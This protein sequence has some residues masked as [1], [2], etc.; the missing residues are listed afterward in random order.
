MLGWLSNRRS[1]EASKSLR[2]MPSPLVQRPPVDPFA[3]GARAE[4]EV[5]AHFRRNL[6]STTL[7]LFNIQFDNNWGD[8]DLIVFMPNGIFIWDV[9]GWSPRVL[10]REER[11]EMGV[12]MARQ[13]ETVCRALGSEL[14]NIALSTPHKG[15]VMAY[16]QQDVPQIGGAP[17]MSKEQAVEY[18]LSQPHVLTQEQAY[19]IHRIGLE[20]C[21]LQGPPADYRLQPA[22]ETA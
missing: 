2:P 15:F 11:V 19:R 21:I 12:K 17:T 1:R 18:M 3:I 7:M 10:T 16:A 9:K 6:P 5:R 8:I 22:R 20:R 4:E 13:W 14:R